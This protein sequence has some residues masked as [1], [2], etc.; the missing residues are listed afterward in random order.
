MNET[1]GAIMDAAEARIR[2]DGYGGFSFREIATDIGIKSASVHYHFPTKEMLAASVAH[3]YTDRF[4]EALDERITAGD[5][6]VGACRQ[7]FRTAF[8]RDGKMCLCGALGATSQ[9]LAPEIKAEVKRFFRCGIDRLVKE[10]L[11]RNDAVRVF[12]TLEG[13][14]LTA[15]VLEDPS[16]FEDGTAAL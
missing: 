16:L 14:M 6:I 15:N 5:D 9:G 2:R 3:R 8:S 12:A 4:F 13:A 7:V 1:A 11:S 10:G